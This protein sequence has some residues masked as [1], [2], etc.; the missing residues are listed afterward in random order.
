LRAAGHGVDPATVP[1]QIAAEQGRDLGIVV[2]DKDVG[3]DWIRRSTGRLHG[4]I[5]SASLGQ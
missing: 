2:H 1:T 5:W 4:D 3:T